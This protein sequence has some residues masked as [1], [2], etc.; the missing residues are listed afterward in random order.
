MNSESGGK[1]ANTNENESDAK[2]E[3]AGMPTSKGFLL[4]QSDRQLI[5]DNAHTIRDAL[6]VCTTEP[7]VECA[8]AFAR[9]LSF[10][11]LN[12]DNYWLFMRLIMTNNKWVVDELLA[13]RIPRLLFS[14]IRPDA[15]LLDAAFEMLFSRHPEEI[16]GKSLECVLGIIQ[17]AYFDPDDGYRIRRLSIMDIN[18]L[19]KFLVK[20][21]GQDYPLNK[22]ILEILDRLAHLG[23]YYGEQDKN[24]LSR[25]AFNVRYAYFDNTRDLIDA[26]PEPLLIPMPDL[27]GGVPEKD[28]ANLISTRSVQKRN[29][30]GRAIEKRRDSGAID[31]NDAQKDRRDNAKKGDGDGTDNGVGKGSGKGSGK[32]P[33]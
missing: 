26:I 20:G 10:C 4:A 3:F 25:H 19:G 13:E 11:G 24:V 28:F 32:A 1:Q 7:Q 6:F 18:A 12:G 5:E 31:G 17:N 29:V 2:K 21:E 16:Y 33:G 14:T 9:Y 22:L 15:D 27:T 30:H 23:D 8:I